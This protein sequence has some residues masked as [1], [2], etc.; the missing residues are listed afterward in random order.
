MSKFNEVFP[1]VIRHIPLIVIQ[2]GKVI[3]QNHNKIKRFSYKRASRT[4]LRNLCNIKKFTA[5]KNPQK[6]KGWNEWAKPIWYWLELKTKNVLFLSGTQT[7]LNPHWYNGKESLWGCQANLH[8]VINL[9]VVISNILVKYELLK[10]KPG[11]IA[12]SVDTLVWSVWGYKH[13]RGG[14]ITKELEA[15]AVGHGFWWKEPTW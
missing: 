2:K 6:W 8:I 12:P 7:F 5:K 9:K 15:L 4:R 10:C 13:V 3:H 1:N 14:V 11:I